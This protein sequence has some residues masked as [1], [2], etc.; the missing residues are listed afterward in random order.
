MW[1]D[2][3]VW[4]QCCCDRCE[5]DEEVRAE[6]CAETRDETRCCGEGDGLF[7]VEIETVQG[8]ESYE[9][10]DGGVVC[11][12]LCVVR[13]CA[14]VRLAG[15]LEWVSTYTFLVSAQLLERALG[16]TAQHA[17]HLDS[18]PLQPPHLTP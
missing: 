12:K 15:W 10:T 17:Q 4:Y 14:T 8:A 18:T 11:F 3:R 6:V 9:G 5:G 2:I 1:W 7:D 16:R 13:S